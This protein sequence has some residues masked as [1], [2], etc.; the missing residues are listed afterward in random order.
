MSKLII[1]GGRDFIGTD[2]DLKLLADLCDR[3][4]ITEI[5]SGCAKGADTFGEHFANLFNLSITRFPADWNKWGKSAGYR[6][7][8]QMAQYTDYVHCFPGGKGTQHMRN[9]AIQLNKPLI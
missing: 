6:R 9:I 3:Y 8:Y 4:K 2:K 5:V 7:N 1:A